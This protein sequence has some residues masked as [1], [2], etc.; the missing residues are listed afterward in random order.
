MI[1]VRK[2][3]SGGRQPA[4][5]F[6]KRTR[7]VASAIVRQTPADVLANAV[8]CA[9][10]T[11]HGGLTSPALVRALA[12]RRNCDFCDAQTQTQERRPSARRAVANRMAGTIT[13]IFGNARPSQRQER[14]VLARR[15]S[16]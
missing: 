2:P 16:R 14:R 4:V 9:L 12:R 6:G 13:Y 5:V 3:K 15:A 1:V 10:P 7:T 8:A 11:I